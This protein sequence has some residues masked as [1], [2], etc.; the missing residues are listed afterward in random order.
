MVDC[1]SF[2]SLHSFV[3][4][5]CKIQIFEENKGFEGI[6]RIKVQVV[7]NPSSR[8]EKHQFFVFEGLFIIKKKTK[9]KNIFHIFK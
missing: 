1:K 2:L 6:F 8:L 4:Q 7:S 3:V 9:K 5:K